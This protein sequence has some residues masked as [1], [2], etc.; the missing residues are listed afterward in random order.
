MS[1]KKVITDF[2][3]QG[4]KDVGLDA[5]SAND[6]VANLNANTL[7]MCVGGTDL[8]SID[9]DDVVIVFLVLDGS[10][11]MAPVQSDV[12][13][14]FNETLIPA[15]KGASSKT[16]QAMLIGGLIFNNQVR[17]LWRDGF[18]KLEDVPELTLTD[19]QPG[20]STALYRA[21]LDALSVTSVYS[22][23]V[24]GETN[25][26]PKVV[27]AVLSDGANNCSPDDPN[28][29]EK[30]ASKLSKEIFTLA[31]AGFETGE[32]VDFRDIAQATGFEAVWETKMQPGESL[33]DQR[34][35]LR[36]LFG[37]LSSSIVSTSTS[38]SGGF[39]Q[40]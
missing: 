37:T 27:V 23:R 30:I 38:A 5:E 24:I 21:M 3:K 39:W 15:L 18:R 4:A 33:D 6:V 13:R 2:Q 7:P 14:E 20:G 25:T 8:S 34:R 36:H 16:R 19:Y 9:T 32:T 29:V 17:P 10:G 11:S 12:I 40:D 22:S 1:S 35:R 28:E 26:P 31:F